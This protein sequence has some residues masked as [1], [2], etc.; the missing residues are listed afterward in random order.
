MYVADTLKNQVKKHT[1]G[2][3]KQA[4]ESKYPE[5]HFHCC[6]VSIADSHRHQKLLIVSCYR[7]PSATSGNVNDVF[8]AVAKIPGDFTHTIVAGDFNV[9][10]ARLGSQKTDVAGKNLLD[11]LN[12]SPY[13][14]LNDG[15]PTRGQAV[16]D[17]TVAELATVGCISK[18]K[19]IASPGLTDHNTIVFH[20]KFPAPA[21]KENATS[22]WRLTASPEAWECFKNLTGDWIEYIPGRGA[23][24]NADRL[25]NQITKAAEWSIGRVSNSNKLHP[26]WNDRLQQLK[27][28]KRQIQRQLTTSLKEK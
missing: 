28:E 27:I 24:W 3:D 20:F 21:S 14:I 11:Y 16:L 1:V 10:H 5:E 9:H 6:A 22:R 23:E 17:L 26:W 4:E 7:S 12:S 25:T 15:T 19:T 8:E 13:H 18:W 2:V